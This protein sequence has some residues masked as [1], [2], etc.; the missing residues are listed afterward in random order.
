MIIDFHAHVGDL[1]LSTNDPRQPITWDNLLA[2]LDAESIDMAVVLP[3]YNA[4]PESAPPG[5][6][7]LD[8]RMSVRDQVIDAGRYPERIIPFGN[9]DPRWIG[10]SPKSD[11]SVILDWFLAHGCK[12]M[13]EV[14][15]NVLFDDP[16]TINMFQ[17][18]GAKGLLVT[19]ESAGL[20]A[21]PYGLQDDPGMPRLERLLRAAPETIIIAHGPGFWA[22]M[23]AGITP[24]QKWSY[25]KGPIREEGATWRLLRT[26]PNLYADLSANSGYN[27]VT[28]DLETGIRFLNEFQDKLLFGTDICFVD[29]P[30]R[31]MLFNHL[32]DL[33]HGGDLSPQAY[34]KIMSA[35]GLRLLGMDPQ[36]NRI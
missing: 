17:Q 14:T 8:E 15:A 6:A 35:N 20:Y 31:M 9:M 22:E 24:E 7:L 4:S 16:R 18:C 25:P 11:F 26:C 3:V 21:G 10:N 30:E 33:K 23:A 29:A 5:I 2:R 34:E 12:G 1:R 36:N 27:A 13:G 28:R 19:I 32:R